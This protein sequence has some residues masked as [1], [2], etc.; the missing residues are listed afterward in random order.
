MAW[1]EKQ[2]MHYFNIHCFISQDNTVIRLFHLSQRQCSS[3]VPANVSELLLF[4]VQFQIQFYNIDIVYL[5][6]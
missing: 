3:L 6:V 5:R 4:S 2:K 1:E